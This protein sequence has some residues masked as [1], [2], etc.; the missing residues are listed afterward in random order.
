MA[1]NDRA[2]RYV[3]KRRRAVEHKRFV[4][5]KG[6]YAADIQRPGMLHVALVASPYASARIVSLDASAALAMPPWPTS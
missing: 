6:R 5:G 2:F 4:V 1:E 3:G